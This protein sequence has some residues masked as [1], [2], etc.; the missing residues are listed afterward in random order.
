MEWYKMMYRG[1][2]RHNEAQAIND[3]LKYLDM[4]TKSILKLVKPEA[5]TKVLELLDREVVIDHMILKEHMYSWTPEMVTI[6]VDMVQDFL[7]R[8]V[9]VHAQK[10]QEET[11]A[12]EV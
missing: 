3:S 12:K 11:T 5:K 7:D 1:E 4:A 8:M 6:V 9:E 2:I 10:E